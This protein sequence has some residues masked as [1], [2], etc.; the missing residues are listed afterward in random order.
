MMRNTGNMNVMGYDELICD[1]II[2]MTTSCVLV[3]EHIY[4]RVEYTFC[5]LFMQEEREEEIEKISLNMK[6]VMCGL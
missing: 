5:M 2:R 4:D 3:L 1:V 6:C